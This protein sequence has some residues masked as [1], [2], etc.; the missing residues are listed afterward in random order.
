MS[1]QLIRRFLYL[2]IRHSRKGDLVMKKMLLVMTMMVA[3]LLSATVL[4]AQSPVGNWKTISD[5]TGKPASIVSIYEQNGLLY[6][7]VIE[8][9]NPAEK[10]NVCEKC[11]GAEKGKLI[12]G[13]VII[14]GLKADGDQYSGGTILDPSNGKVYKGKLKVIEGGKKLKVSG[15]IAFICVGKEWVKAE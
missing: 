2:K 7:N 3:F 11:E 8:L 10:K 12:E 4:W 14:K 6:G 9:L 1:L 5:K 13:M 15:C